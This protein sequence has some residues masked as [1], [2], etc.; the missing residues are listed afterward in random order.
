V[1]TIT[2]VVQYDHVTEVH[3]ASFKGHYR[4]LV[5]ERVEDFPFELEGFVTL[6][7]D[8]GNYNA[9][10]LLV[11]NSCITHIEKLR[12]MKMTIIYFTADYQWSYKLSDSIEDIYQQMKASCE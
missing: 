3:W 2:H 5:T 11:R 12:G 4:E 7:P 6:S 1:A 8:R 10:L 9:D